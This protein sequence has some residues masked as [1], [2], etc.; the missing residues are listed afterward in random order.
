MLRYTCQGKRE[1]EKE[2]PLEN[3][4]AVDNLF[5]SGK[6]MN[7]GEKF[8]R[9]PSPGKHND[10]QAQGLEKATRDTNVRT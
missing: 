9:G 2:T 4:K 8:F 10:F 6:R 5:S 1:R 7:R 3:V